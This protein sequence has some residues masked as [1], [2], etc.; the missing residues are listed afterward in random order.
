MSL[1]VMN[2][3]HWVTMQ[4]KNHQQLEERWHLSTSTSQETLGDTD[5]I[6]KEILSISS[7]RFWPLNSFAEVRRNGE[8]RQTQILLRSEFYNL[9]SSLT[10]NRE[11]GQSNNSLW[12][13]TSTRVLMLGAG[14]G[15]KISNSRFGLLHVTM[16]CNTL[17]KKSEQ[18]FY[19]LYFMSKLFRSYTELANV[20]NST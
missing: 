4:R 8:A 12:G 16:S 15:S 17:K 7:P 5:V 18:N 14:S 10:T 9:L 20:L 3:L 11:K 1:K 2:I 19:S 13:F 6:Y